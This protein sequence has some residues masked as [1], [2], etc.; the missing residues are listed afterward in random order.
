MA[1][2]A[3]SA[4][5]AD[6]LKNGKSLPALNPNEEAPP[7]SDVRPV[8]SPTAPAFPE[9]LPLVRPRVRDAGAVA[10]VM[11]EIVESGVLTNGPYVRRFEQ[12]AA[13]Y[14]DV[15]HC[16]AVSSCT[17]GLML[18]LRAANLKGDVIV[19][20]FTFAAT[21]HAIR[22]NGLHPMFA[23]IDPQTLTLSAEAV[24]RAAGIRTSA[25]L[26]TH[27]YGTPCDVEALTAVADRAGLQLFFDAAHAFGSRHGDRPVGGFGAAEVFSLSPTKVLFAAE[28]GIIATNDDALAERCRI[29]RDYGHPGD[30][31]CRFVGLNARMSEPHAV[32]ALA[33]FEDLDQR[34]DERNDTVRKLRAA[35]G[36]V[37]GVEFPVV[38]AGDRSTFKDFTILVDP[39]VFGMSADELG[40][41]LGAEGVET[42]RYYA[43][44]VHRMIAYEGSIASNGSL[45]ATD[46]ASSRALTL[47]L[48]SGMTDDH[49]ARLAGAVE[50]IQRGG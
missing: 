28:G 33:S 20:S 34:I 50:R 30:Y 21:A 49:V 42:K 3:S 10:K 44:P 2:G 25:I 14:L 47:P 23:D 43:P 48:W 15:R 41:A 19:P 29:G 16:I 6:R 7:M 36:D 38:P 4:R 45:Q 40:A 12:E 22:W 26:A 5:A 18:V 17:A 24:E 9:G 39:E 31:N 46:R 11:R 1:L 37:P 27:I 32:V 13:D 35:L 8:S